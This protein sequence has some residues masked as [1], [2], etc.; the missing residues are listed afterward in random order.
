MFYVGLNLPQTWSEP[1]TTRS[2]VTLSKHVLTLPLM[3]RL[4]LK[5][6]R[7]SILTC[8]CQMQRLIDKILIIPTPYDAITILHQLFVH[9][10]SDLLAHKVCKPQ[11][12]A[13]DIVFYHDPNDSVPIDTTSSAPQPSSSTNPPQD[14]FSM[15][16]NT[17]RK[18]TPVTAGAR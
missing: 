9:R 5:D 4:G 8:F 6:S 16:L 14:A 12:D 15:L 2:S 11:Q 18:P 3:I 10:L 7:A 1:Q 17:G 13:K